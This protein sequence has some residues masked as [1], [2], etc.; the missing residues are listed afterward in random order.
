MK[1]DVG[2]SKKKGNKKMPIAIPRQEVIDN[3]IPISLFFCLKGVVV[4][5][6]L[7]SPVSTNNRTTRSTYQK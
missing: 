7:A 3:P 5:P 4:C 1:G 6:Q 2:M